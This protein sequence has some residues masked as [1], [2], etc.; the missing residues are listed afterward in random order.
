ML[1]KKPYLTKSR[2]T[3]PSPKQWNSCENAETQIYS[4]S[5]H[6]CKNDGPFIEQQFFMMWKTTPWYLSHFHS[7][8]IAAPIL[9]WAS[10]RLCL[11]HLKEVKQFRYSRL[12]RKF[13]ITFLDGF[14]EKQIE[15]SMAAVCIDNSSMEWNLMCVQFFRSMGTFPAH[16]RMTSL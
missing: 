11:C 7:F 4:K 6:G 15:S 12:R 2:K 3:P 10:E 8:P 16:K 14:D 9:L 13:F 1:M 5:A